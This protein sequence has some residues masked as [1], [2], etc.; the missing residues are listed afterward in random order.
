MSNGEQGKI[1]PNGIIGEKF[2]ANLQSK[3]DEIHNANYEDYG[4]HAHKII[5]N[6]KDTYRD[7][8]GNFSC[9]KFTLLTVFGFL[10][11]INILKNYNIK[12]DA[13]KDLLC[14]LTVFIMGIPQGM[15]AGVL[16]GLGPV[17]GLYTSTFPV[18]IYFFFGTSRQIALGM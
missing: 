8:E 18:C 15:A 11:F 9:K 3:F 1:V 2:K 13:L 12:K 17:H 5:R 4:I 16:S 14:G 10:P 7:E 6:W